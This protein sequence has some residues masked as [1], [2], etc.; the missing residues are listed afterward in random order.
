[1]ARPTLPDNPLEREY[2]TLSRKLR[3]ARGF[4]FVV[5]FVED[6]R[7]SAF[8]KRRLDE[9]MGKDLV[10]IAEP[11]ADKF[12][13]TTLR[14]V[15]QAGVESRA[16]ERR[17]VYWV[18]AFRGPGEPDWEAQRRELLM[19]MNERRGRLESELQAPLILLLPART[20]R[21]AAS[22]APDLWHVR[23]HSAV[24]S[25]RGAGLETF[26]VGA[27]GSTTRAGSVSGVEASAQADTIPRS[28]TYWNAQMAAANREQ[29]AGANAGEALDTLAL[30]DGFSA[31]N[32]WLAVG[33][34]AEAAALADDLLSMARDRYARLPDASLHASEL[35]GALTVAGDALRD[36]GQ[37]DAAR[38]CYRDAIEIA[39]IVF[40]SVSQVPLA[41]H[42]T[43]GLLERLGGVEMKLGQVEDALA[44][45]REAVT[46]AR[47]RLDVAMD[48][49]DAWR[50]LAG[51][52]DAIALACRRIADHDAALAASH[53]A[54]SVWRRAASMSG[55][56]AV[57]LRGLA[58][59]L[60]AEGAAEQGSV[61]GEAALA[62]YRESAGLA[63][64]LRTRTPD[65]PEPIWML[66]TVLGL[67]AVAEAAASNVEDAWVVAEEALGLRRELVRLAPGSTAAIRDLDVALRETADIAQLAG[68]PDLAR[69][70]REEPVSLPIEATPQTVRPD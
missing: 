15:F 40:D 18:E 14:D 44:A 42:A 2:Q 49:V 27:D 58:L 8:I 43:Q 36:D 37:F 56:D 13:S 67:I 39:R 61:R 25:A 68:H 63:R 16:S 64:Q 50:G 52:L 11:D 26:A 29:A 23:L 69:R 4:C 19:R 30:S 65:N 54:S 7:A 12:A 41:W 33:R 10:E 35:L 45:Y 24:L 1:M 51:T 66:A 55:Q 59:S 48:D 38:D 17:R 20:Q 5:Y 3:A 57:D 21:E 31:V 46:L 28:V 6:R 34:S 22:L 9:S 32:A 47:R 62:A 70:L 60:M 53:E